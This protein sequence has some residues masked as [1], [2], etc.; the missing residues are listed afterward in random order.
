M[1]PASTPTRTATAKAPAPQR[2]PT[3]GRNTTMKYL[4]VETGAD[5]RRWDTYIV[6]VPD[7][8]NPDAED[9]D[10]RLIELISLG[11]GKHQGDS[12]YEDD[13][14]AVPPGEFT[15]LESSPAPAPAD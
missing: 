3:T 15:I 2:G 8:W 11:R 13:G 7:D 4:T 10:R 1:T 12:E 5:V 6:A 14:T 9:S